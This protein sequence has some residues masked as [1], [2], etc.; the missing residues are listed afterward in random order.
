[1]ASESHFEKSSL[2]EKIVEHVF[3]GEVLTALWRK[4][5]TDAELLRSEF[6][7]FGYDIVVERG[8]L[9][10]HVQLKS[11][12]NKLSRIGV[13][14]SLARKQSGCVIYIHLTEGLD[15]TAFYWLG[16]SPGS[17][18]PPTAQYPRLKR[19]T[20]NKEGIKPERKGHRDVPR[21]AFEGPMNLDS[22]LFKLLGV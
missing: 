20:P 13:S 5:V 8:P 21:A 4:G 12:I 2:R 6:D 9:T 17:A 16:G 11:G 22:L 10:R 19:T 1:M 3:I 18:L 15:L 7:A 14:D